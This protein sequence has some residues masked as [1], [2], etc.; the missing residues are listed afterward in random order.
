MQQGYF[1]NDAIENAAHDNALID[2]FKYNFK[3]MHTIHH[4]D[5]LFLLLGNIIKFRTEL[6]DS[7][8]SS[9]NMRY[10]IH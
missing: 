9:C 3:S 1:Q 4:I 7:P 5:E 8:L 2:S 6:S 10:P